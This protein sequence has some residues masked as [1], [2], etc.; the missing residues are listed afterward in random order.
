VKNVVAA[1]GCELRTGRRA[2]KMG[3][4]HVYRDETRPG[5]RPLERQ[6]L[7][8]IGAADFLSLKIVR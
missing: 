3:S 6:A 7:T 4:P 5:V 2:I 8:L 1:G